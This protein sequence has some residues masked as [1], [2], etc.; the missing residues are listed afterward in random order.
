MQTDKNNSLNNKLKDFVRK[1]HSNKDKINN[2]KQQLKIKIEFE[3]QREKE[4]AQIENHV[5]ELE[6]ALT[7]L[8]GTHVLFYLQL[9]S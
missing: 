7:S 1:H 3:T 4:I 9:S 8:N 5:K 6:D 2:I